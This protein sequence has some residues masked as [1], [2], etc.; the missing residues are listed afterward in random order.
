MV[1][2]DEVLD[3]LHRDQTGL[4]A[5]LASIVEICRGYSWLTEGR[6]PYPF[7]D[8]RY[9]D[10]IGRC[11][12]EIRRRAATALRDSGASAHRWCCGPPVGERRHAP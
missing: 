9:R 8:D 7:D 11:L 2:L 12:D 1:T 4:A 3:A 5:A 10:E 6:G